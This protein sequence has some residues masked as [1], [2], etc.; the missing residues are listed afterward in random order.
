MFRSNI[1]MPICKRELKTYSCAHSYTVRA[2]MPFLWGMLEWGGG[3][4]SVN[5][6]TNQQIAYEE[7][8]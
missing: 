7:K 4:G 8:H 6:V 2:D 5:G 1:R 3:G